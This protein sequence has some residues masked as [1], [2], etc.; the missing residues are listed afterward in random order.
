MTALRVVGV[1][2]S[3]EHAGGPVHVLRGVDLEVAAGELVT[4]SGPSGSG[5]SALLTVLSGFDRADEGTVELCGEVMTTPPTW[6]RCA[7]LPQALSLA[8]ELTLAENVALPLRLGTA[9]GSGPV[10]V[11]RV[12]ELLAE[13][14]IGELADRYPGEVS[15][16]QQQ[17]AA[18]ARAVVGSPKVLLAD[19]PTAHLDR[20]SA[21]TAVRVLRRA[22]DEGAAVLI[23]THHDE[24]H[25][26]ADRTVV[27]SAGRVSVD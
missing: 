19:E 23:A 25:R 6:Q 11:S 17:R 7:L 10:D 27:L 13:L 8:G 5:K 12:A 1:R 14:G 3:F 20:V 15:F 4:L 9:A 18:L 24:V 16:G 26:A 21:P 2:R 22:A